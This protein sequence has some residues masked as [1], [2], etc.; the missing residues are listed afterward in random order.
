LD[1][2]TPKNAKNNT[3]K[4]LLFVANDFLLKGG[5][6]LI[7]IY[8]RYF[9]N[10]AVL[11]IISNDPFLKNMQ[12]PKG[13]ELLSGISH[14]S[15]NTLPELYRSSD[16]LIHPTKKDFLPIV[17]IEGCASGLPIIASNIGAVS[18]AVKDGYNG[19]VMGT[20]STKEK[21]AEKI[22]DLLKNDEKRESFG[23]NSRIL[24]EEKFSINNFN[25]NIKKAFSSIGFK[26]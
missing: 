13:V 11:R 22:S 7:D 26:I 8:C 24:A 21:W 2:W 3:S 20:S 9:S 18:E 17:L 10:E 4:I 14:S 5:D 25:N 19:Y 12:L 15:Q 23:K 1:T 16:I 6:F